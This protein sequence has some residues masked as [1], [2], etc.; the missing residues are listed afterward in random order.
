MNFY[1][2]VMTSRL[3]LLGRAL[4]FISAVVILV[5]LNSTLYPLA[6]KSTA[7]YPIQLFLS[8]IVA[9]VALFAAGLAYFILF[10]I[11]TAVG[12]VFTGEFSS[13]ILDFA[14]DLLQYVIAFPF[15]FIFGD[16][17]RQWLKKKE[18]HD[19]DCICNN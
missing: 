7:P 8:F 4:V 13:E 1:D 11:A 9:C 19:E 15:M 3:D 5:L 12:W 2:K 16:W 14:G 10:L 17:N 18:K 6:Y